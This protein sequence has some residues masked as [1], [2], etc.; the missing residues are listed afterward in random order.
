MGFEQIFSDKNETR[1]QRASKL[2]RQIENEEAAAARPTPAPPGIFSDNNLSASQVIER[3]GLP[4]GHAQ[5]IE[6]AA[7]V[8]PVEVEDE[9][10]PEETVEEVEETPSEPQEDP[11]EDS[12]EE[13]E[14]EAPVEDEEAAED[15]SQPVEDETGEKE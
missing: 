12:E 15:V 10:E 6:E 5:R 3:Q 7:E 13:T 2:D 9:V 8:A 4:E 11:V 14:V 1:E